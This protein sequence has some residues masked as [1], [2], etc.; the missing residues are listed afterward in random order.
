MTFGA[1]SS[2]LDWNAGR[3]LGAR[4]P[5]SRGA[6]CA[7]ASLASLETGRTGAV[8]EVSLEDGLRRW[9]E[10]IGIGCGDRIT[11]LRRAPFGGPLHVRTHTGGEF[12]L[13]R[14]LARCIHIDRDEGQEASSTT[15][16][17]TTMGG[18]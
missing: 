14:G 12:A 2:V 8:V 13:D 7:L 5:A 18:A 15:L 6:L 10:A 4:P 11:V 9:L 3:A 17:S 16:R 1:P